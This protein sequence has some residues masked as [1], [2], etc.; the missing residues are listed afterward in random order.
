MCVLDYCSAT[1]VVLSLVGLCLCLSLSIS[2]IPIP[3]WRGD[4]VIF[5][6]IQRQERLEVIV[7]IDR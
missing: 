6:G 5:K 7:S 1:I 4:V 3:S 2:S